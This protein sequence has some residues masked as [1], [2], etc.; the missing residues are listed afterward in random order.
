[1]SEYKIPVLPEITGTELFDAEHSV[2]GYKAVLADDKY[3]NFGVGRDENDAL[4]QLAT[5]VLSDVLN[6]SD[7][8]LMGEG[9]NRYEVLAVL[10]AR[11]VFRNDNAPEFIAALHIDYACTENFRDSMRSLRK[12]KGWSFPQLGRESWVTAG[13]LCQ[14]ENGKSMPSLLIA[15]QIAGGLGVSLAKMVGEE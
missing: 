9:A 14:I 13:H 11:F 4:V 10:F 6:D 1:M 8:L 12:G 15:L 7:K 5:K 3:T 2:S